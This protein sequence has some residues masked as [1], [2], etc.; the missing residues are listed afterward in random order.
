M[1]DQK[2]LEA[3]RGPSLSLVAHSSLPSTGVSAQE[4]SAG[5]GLP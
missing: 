2:V 3:G 1:E 5:E 4:L